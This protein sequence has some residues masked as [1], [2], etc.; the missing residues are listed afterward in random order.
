[1]GGA[2]GIGEDP[3]IRALTHTLEKAAL[4]NYK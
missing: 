2:G 1:M 4:V 3:V